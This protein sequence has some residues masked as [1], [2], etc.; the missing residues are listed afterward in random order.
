MR[1]F[2]GR[3]SVCVCVSFPFGFDGGMLDLIPDHCLSFYF[4]RMA[5]KADSSVV[6]AE[7]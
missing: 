7:L 3:L 1:V 6:L 2:H 4:S 5:A